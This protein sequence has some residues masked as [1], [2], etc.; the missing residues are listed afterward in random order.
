LYFSGADAKGIIGQEDDTII[1]N[2]KTRLAE[3]FREGQKTG[4]LYNE[5]IEAGD[6]FDVPVTVKRDKLTF[7][8][9]LED[10]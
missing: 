7:E 1:F 8:K 9:Q 3:G 2:S 4:N 10:V 6:F 5:H